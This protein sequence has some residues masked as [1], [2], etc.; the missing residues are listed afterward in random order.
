MVAFEKNLYCVGKNYDIY[1]YTNTC[2]IFERRKHVIYYIYFTCICS[3][4]VQSFSPSP[5]L[6]NYSWHVSNQIIA[7][8]LKTS[9]NN[10]VPYHT[11]PWW[12]LRKFSLFVCFVWSVL[13]FCSFFSLQSAKDTSRTRSSIL[14]FRI[15]PSIQCILF[16]CICFLF[17]LKLV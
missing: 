13:C 15:R 2:I 8:F 3:K 10:I 9:F 6:A 12:S 14:S 4:L 1:I 11:H 16:Y 5:M 17:C 7:S